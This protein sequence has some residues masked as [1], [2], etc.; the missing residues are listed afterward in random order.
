[1]ANEDGDTVSTTT[2][3]IEDMDGR[4]LRD[5]HDDIR[6]TIRAA[7]MAQRRRPFIVRATLRHGGADILCDAD[8]LSVLLTNALRAEGVTAVRGLVVG[9]DNTRAAADGIDLEAVAEKEL[10]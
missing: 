3:D 9:L 6:A 5:L 10:A 7:R 4:S 2:R 1:M 8:V